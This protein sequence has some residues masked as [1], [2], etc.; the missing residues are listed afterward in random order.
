M[1]H[2][3]EEIR[4]LFC[5]LIFLSFFLFF[6]LGTY[7]CIYNVCKKILWQH[8]NIYVMHEKLFQFS[9][10]PLLDKSEKTISFQTKK[11]FKRLFP[12]I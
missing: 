3:A 9:S 6:L 8:D 11:L 4:T 12:D 1:N 10:I 5:S 7:F 2:V